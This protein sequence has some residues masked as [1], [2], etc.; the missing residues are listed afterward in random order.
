M[1]HLKTYKSKIL[2]INKV[3]DLITMTTYI[4]KKN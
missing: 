4:K 3:K 1:K 2:E